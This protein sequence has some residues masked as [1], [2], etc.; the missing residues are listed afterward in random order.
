MA[1]IETLKLFLLGMI[2]AVGL[3]FLMGADYSGQVGRYPI[4]PGR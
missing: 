1:K 4:F 3:M 2:A